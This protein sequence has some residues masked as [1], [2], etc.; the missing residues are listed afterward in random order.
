MFLIIA[1][2]PVIFVPANSLLNSW[3]PGL[4]TPYMSASFVNIVL[5]TFLYAI[6][7]GF[8]VQIYMHNLFG[9]LGLAIDE[10]APEQI[11]AEKA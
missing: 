1:L 5:E 11:V 7:P 2:L 8:I 4:L 9:Q 3:G 6:F 10:A